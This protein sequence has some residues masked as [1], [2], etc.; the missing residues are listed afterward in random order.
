MHKPTPSKLKVVVEDY[1]SLDNKDIEMM[2]E[3]KETVI[4]LEN[5]NEEFHLLEASKVG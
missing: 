2:Y 1:V 5:Y 4:G 3:S